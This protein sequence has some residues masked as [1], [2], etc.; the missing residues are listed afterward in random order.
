MAA[1]GRGE[2]GYLGRLCAVGRARLCLRPRVSGSGGDLA[3]GV[4]AVRRSCS[5]RRGRRG[6]R[7]NGDASGGVGRGAACPRAGRREDPGEHRDETAVLLAWGVAACRRRWTGAGPLRVRGRGCDFRGRLRRH[8]A[9]G[10]DGALAGYSP[11]NRRTAA[12]RRDRGRRCVRS[13]AAGSGVVADL[14]G[15][16]RR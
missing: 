7:P 16:R 2:C 14:G 1:R 6:R 10:V 13:G 4:G 15:Q 8:W 3:A 11:D 5:P 12:R 9:A